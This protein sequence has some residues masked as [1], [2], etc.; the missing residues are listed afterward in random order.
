MTSTGHKSGNKS[1]KQPMKPFPISFP[2]SQL[3]ALRA[4]SKKREES[5]ASIVREMVRDA[6]EEE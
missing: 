5:V 2:A 6:M 4:E 1:K 3:K